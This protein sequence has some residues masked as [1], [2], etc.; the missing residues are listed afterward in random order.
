MWLQITEAKHK[1]KVSV[2]SSFWDLAVEA[3]D[4]IV[5]LIPEDI[6]FGQLGGLEKIYRWMGPQKFVDDFI[7]DTIKRDERH[8]GGE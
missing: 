6:P 3:R 7:E 4:A 1:H 2:A 8:A 5:E